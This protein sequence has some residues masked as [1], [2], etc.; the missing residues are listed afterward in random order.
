MRKLRSEL[1]QS[2]EKLRELL[3]VNEMLDSHCRALEYA[4]RDLELQLEAAA[5]SSSDGEHGPHKVFISSTVLLQ[6]TVF[7]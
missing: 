4:K 7:C 1:D 6:C 3:A 5:D 2:H